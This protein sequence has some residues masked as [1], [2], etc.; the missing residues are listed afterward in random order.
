MSADRR[1]PV[2][3]QTCGVCCC[4]LL[5]VVCFV[6]CEMSC[7][8]ATLSITVKYSKT[9]TKSNDVLVFV[10]DAIFTKINEER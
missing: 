6:V 1:I 4:V 2:V 10:G 7:N 9:M 3:Q 8:V 5:V